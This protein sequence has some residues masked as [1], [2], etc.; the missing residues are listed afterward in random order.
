MVLVDTSLWV[1]HFR[2]GRADLHALLLNSQVYCHPFIIGELACGHLKNRH[3]I[4]ALLASLQ[5]A[6]LSED[7]E[8]LQLIER[9]RLYGRG[10][11]WIDFHLLSSALLSGTRLWTLD[12]ALRKIA[13]EFDL[14]Y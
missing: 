10:L 8:V 5:Q 3:E 2:T 11:G 7:E 1:E 13:L 9:N 12:K 14:A 6:F 4:L